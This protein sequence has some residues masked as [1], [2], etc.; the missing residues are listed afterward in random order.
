MGNLVL[1]IIIYVLLYLSI[2]AYYKINNFRN[3]F[4]RWGISYKEDVK[5][6]EKLIISFIINIPLLIVLLFNLFT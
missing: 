5:L 1:I 2:I 3:P 6:R 4:S